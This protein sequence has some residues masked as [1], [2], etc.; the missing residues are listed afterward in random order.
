MSQEPLH[1]SYQLGSLELRNRLVMAPLTRNRAGTGNVPTDLMA[2]YYEQRASFGLVITEATPVSETG[3]GYPSTPGIY[4]A[5]QLTGWKEVT[6][7]VHAKGGAIFSQLWHVGRISH[8]DYQ[9]NGKAPLSSSAVAAQGAEIWK[10]DW[11]PVEGPV[12][13]REM[14]TAEIKQTIEDFRQATL[15]AIAA[16]FDGVEIHA[17]NGYLINQ[18]LVD[19]VNQ[20]EDEYGGSIEN[21]SRLLFEILAAATDAWPG[22]VALRLSPSGEFNDITDSDR[23]ALYTRVI[24]RLN[25][26]DLAYLHIVEP[27]MFADHS[28]DTYTDSL[29]TKDWRPLYQGTLISS[30]GHLAASANKVIA[31]G[32]ADLVAFGRLALSNPDLAERF[33]TGAPL[34]DYDRDTFYGGTEKGYTDYP[35]LEPATV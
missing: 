13:P 17:A 25:D 8:A 31:D 10:P 35:F 7:R 34:N 6:S 2:T 19:G 23:A 27:R 26:Y 28:L 29:S 32:Q 20:R 15:N 21:R 9:P 1:S 5:D 14:T 3:H 22:R 4:T 12:T 33:E 24:K 11:S 30:G 18:F 16:G